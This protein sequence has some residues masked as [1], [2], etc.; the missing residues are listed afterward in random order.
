MMH[1]MHTVLACIVATAVAF[2]VLGS[3]LAAQDSP[4]PGDVPA[5]GAKEPGAE[6]LQRFFSSLTSILNDA[7]DRFDNDSG[8]PKG[9]W[10]P[11]EETKASNDDRLNALLDECAELL[12]SGKV[13]DIRGKIRALERERQTLEDQ[14]RDAFEK[15]TAAR[16]RSEREWYAVLGKSKEDWDAAIVASQQRQSDID[17]EIFALRREFAGS[18]AALGLEVGPEGHDALLTTVSGDRFVDMALAFDNVRV[19]TEQLRRITERMNESPTTA[20]RYYGMYVLLVRI[21]DR[22]QDSFIEQVESVAIPKV[23]QFGEEAAATKRQAKALLSKADA[24]HK[25]TLE[26]N[27]AACELAQD[28][29]INY[30]AYL[31]AQAERVR[32]LNKSVEVRLKVAENTYRTM[33]VSVGIAELIKQ[34][35][36]DLQA[37]MAMEL[38]ALKGFDNTALR[39]QYEQLNSRLRGN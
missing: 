14:V 10:N 1:M 7:L 21:M 5:E 30:T 3:P 19:V 34:G 24:A 16:P 37:V 38:P 28:A 12:A 17:A 11:F 33:T 26:R 18:I 15:Q 32:D 39:E 22:I 2:P 20:K 29:V 31:Q 8:L 36:L 6:N 25:V 13:T 9:S 27:I 23:K 35:Q 4:P